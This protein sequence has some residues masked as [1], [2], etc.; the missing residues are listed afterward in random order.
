MRNFKHIAVALLL[1]VFAATAV[2]ADQAAWVTKEQAEKAA[3]LLKDK[4]QIRHYCNPCKDK[5]DKVEDIDTVDV[6]KIE[7]E[8][9]WEVKINGE[10]VDLAYVYYLDKKGRW[11]NVATEVKIK[12]SDVPKELK[13]AVGSSE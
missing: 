3:T 9:F 12:V 11:K 5:G 6:A 7:N 1:T 8:D 10:G 2:L 4:K 13:F